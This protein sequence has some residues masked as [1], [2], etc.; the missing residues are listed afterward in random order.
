MDAELYHG[1]E[2]TYAKHLFLEQYLER[3]A[4]HIAYSREEFVYVD[5]FSGPWKATDEGLEDTSFMI[6]IRKLQY[7]REALGKLG[8]SPRIRCLF[9]EA[10]QSRFVALEAATRDVARLETTALHGDFKRSSQT[11]SNLWGPASH[12]S[13]LIPPAGTASPW[14]VSLLC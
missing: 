7:V 1:R 3:V 13:S 11:S 9:I 10:D 5:G 2:Q 4:F 14:N 12:L 8:K 6:A